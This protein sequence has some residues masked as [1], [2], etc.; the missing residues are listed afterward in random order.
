MLKA[1]VGM[2]LLAE[3]D[4]VFTSPAQSSGPAPNVGSLKPANKDTEESRM[5][6]VEGKY[7]RC[8]LDFRL[9]QFDLT[10][11]RRGENCCVVSGRLLQHPDLPMIFKVVDAMRHPDV[12]DSLK[13]EATAYLALEYL[14]GKAIPTLY[15]FY[16]VWEILHILALEPVGEAIGEDEQIDDALRGKMREALRCVHKVGYVHGDIAHQKF[17]KWGCIFGGFGEVLYS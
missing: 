12:A 16:K 7:Q 8:A 6:F 11:A 4:R 10:S 17:C 13:V 5:R 3:D 14:Q 2:V 1:W 9:C 15:R